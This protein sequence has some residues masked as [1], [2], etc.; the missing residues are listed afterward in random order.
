M[1]GFRGLEVWQE[2]KDLAV[3]LYKV[4]QKGAFDRDFSLRIKFAGQA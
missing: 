3:D 1:T 2:G 4:T